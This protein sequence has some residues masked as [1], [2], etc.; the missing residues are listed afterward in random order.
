MKILALESAALTASAAVCEDEH[1]LGETLLNNGHT[2]S[3]TLL[4]MAEAL[5]G[6]LGLTAAD[7]DLFPAP[8]PGS[9]SA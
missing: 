1:L 6:S 7:I 9:G 5:L 3:E 4:P 8:L 2:H